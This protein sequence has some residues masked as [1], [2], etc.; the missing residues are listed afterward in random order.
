MTHRGSR[1]LAMAVAAAAVAATASGCIARTPAGTFFQLTEESA[2]QRAMQTREVEAPNADELLSA[3]AAV[4]Q[5]LG[6]QVTESERALGFLKAAKER[7]AREYWQEFVRG[8]LL[9]VSALGSNNQNNVQIIPVDLHQQI[10]A[11]LV[12]LP[13]DDSG[14]RHR[15]RI[16][17]YRLVWQSEGQNGNTNIPPGRQ[18]MEMIHDAGIYQQFF[19]R[20]AKSV[21]LEEQKI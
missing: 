12:A 19:A 6:F 20:L 16:V 9:V 5:D 1:R 8:F 14:R 15:V 4:L 3:S 17:F 13:V 21:F 11:S 7:S 2:A 18:K 10:N